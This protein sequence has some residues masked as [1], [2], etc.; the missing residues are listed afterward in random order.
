VV[1]DTEEAEEAEGGDFR[2]RGH[3]LL[4]CHEHEEDEVEDIPTAI[5][6]VREVPPWVEALCDHL[7]REL[8]EEN[9]EKRLVRLLE[10]LR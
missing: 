5:F 9:G 10:H 8:E 4:R 7:H 6:H 2:H 3:G 1:R